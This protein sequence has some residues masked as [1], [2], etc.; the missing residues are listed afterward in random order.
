MP[1]R[2]FKTGYG[3]KLFQGHMKAIRRPGLTFQAA[4][5][6]LCTAATL[7]LTTPALSDFTTVV[8]ETSLM[9]DAAIGQIN[10]RNGQL[11]DATGLVVVVVVERGSNVDTAPLDAIS[12]AD[13]LAK[14]NYGALIWV[15]TGGERS[16]IL[17]TG[18]ALKWVSYELQASLRRQL[19]GSMRYCCPSDTVPAAVDQLAS[20]MEAG[21][22]IP[23]S[24]GNYVRDD[25]GV[26]NDQQMSQIVAREER[27]EAAT[28]KGV[29]VVLFPE[30][31]GKLSPQIAYSM[32]TSFRVNGQIA[33]LVWMTRSPQ[34]EHFAVMQTPG[35]TTIPE[36]TE[37]SIGNS[38][39][40]D[41]QTGKFGDAI[42][43]ALDRTA[44]A[45]EDTSTPMPSQAP[46][47]QGSP[48]AGPATAEGS[49]APAAPT[50]A[51]GASGTGT[52]VV[53]FVAFAIIVLVVTLAVRRKNK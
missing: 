17:F 46:S 15:A 32:A 1:Q 7:A 36:A 41:M 22:K 51:P 47:P 35:F 33:A 23:L 27:L 39:Q 24:A 9:S 18:K 30:E 44:T 40:A 20:A 25:L 34:A 3:P 5:C 4:V 50:S 48:S 29:G 45:L 49:A 26:L 8:D 10:T 43:A 11:F 12:A 6:A 14:G 38:F 19:I 28:G 37:Q 2:R 16:D 52:A 53:I 21:S 13:K 42:V 31:P